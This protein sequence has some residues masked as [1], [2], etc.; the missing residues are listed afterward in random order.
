VGIV[1]GTV[2]VRGIYW[3]ATA[4]T[5]RATAW[6]GPYSLVANLT[7]RPFGW[8]LRA[9]GRCDC[10]ESPWA[11]LWGPSGRTRSSASG[12][13]LVACSLG[14]LGC[15]VHRSWINPALSPVG[16]PRLCAVAGLAVSLPA[17]DV[18]RPG[19]QRSG[20]AASSGRWSAALDAVQPAEW[21]PGCASPP[22]PSRQGALV[23]A[24]LRRTR[25]AEVYDLSRLRRPQGRARAVPNGASAVPW[26]SHRQTI[27]GPAPRGL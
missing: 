22:S 23:A 11:I 10:S 16:P 2:Y 20:G 27:K 25:G 17:G 4:K 12:P 13:V 9:C 24:R 18:R 21:S 26:P 19:G 7:C 6:Q 8:A 5:G 1:C 14:P 15:R 3:R